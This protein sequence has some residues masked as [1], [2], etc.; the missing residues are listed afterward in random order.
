M[1]DDLMEVLF[2][3]RPTSHAFLHKEQCVWII[4][5]PRCTNVNMIQI[6]FDINVDV[7]DN[8]LPWL[9]SDGERVVR[10]M[11]KIFDVIR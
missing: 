9:T 4:V 2:F 7:R 1:Y 8:K 10:E 11:V 6:N 3:M 5:T